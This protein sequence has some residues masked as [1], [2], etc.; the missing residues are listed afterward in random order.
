MFIRTSSILLVFSYLLLSCVLIFSCHIKNDTTQSVADEKLVKGKLLANKYCS[1]CH[2]APDPFLLDK[3]TWHNRVLPAMAKQLGLEVWRGNNYYQNEKS[4]IS[5]ADWMQIVAYYDTLAPEHLPVSKSPLPLVKDWSVFS[6]QKPKTDTL[7]TAVTTMVTVDS[8]THSVYT[9]DSEQAGLYQWNSSLKQSG[10]TQLPS[11]AVQMGFQE[12]G[13]SF[14][15]CIGEMKAVDVPAGKLVISSVSN[16]KNILQT[17]TSNLTRPIN[18]VSGD[19]NK[20]GLTDYVVSS[21]GHNKGGLFLVKQLP[22]HTFQN[23]PI[24]E[25]P[26]ATQSIVQ[27]FNQDGWPDIM[28]LFAHGD[29]GIW[30]FLN[31]Q[32]GSFITKN[33]LRFPPVYGSSSFQL[34]DINKDGKQDIV[35]TAGDNSDYSRI[36]KP[37]HGLYIF[38]GM[39]DFKFKQTYFYPIN[40]CTKVM[41]AD[42]DQDG[43]MDINTIA[44]FAD[45][46]NKPE[47]SFIYFEQDNSSQKAVLKF[48]PH[49]IPVYSNG[50]WICMDVNDYDGDGD[51]DIVLGNYSKGFLNQKNLKPNWDVHVPFVVLRNST[52]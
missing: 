41:V 7:K 4:A 1:S 3:E 16:K 43:D 12:D 31:D 33:I 38:T 36:L 21:F 27:D 5:Q 47:E 37:Y 29:E 49:A 11:P 44:F 15:T 24:R 28:T 17:V 35:Y 10:F 39:G 42:I 13:S 34:I 45:L 32:K 2:L 19:F 48:K 26:G 30:L 6:L 40:G 8:S 51:L 23:F 9:S 52:K 46:L 20:D 22:D 18:S 25:V 50:R 14:L